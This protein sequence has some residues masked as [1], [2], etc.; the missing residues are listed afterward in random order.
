MVLDG[1]GN[2]H[3][4]TGIV[5]VVVLPGRPQYLG[6]EVV[7]LRRAWMIFRKV[8]GMGGGTEA[9]DRPTPLDVRCNHRQLFRWQLSK[10]KIEH[11]EIR[12]L[13]RL[14]PFD[15]VSGPALKSLIDED[16]RL[17]SVVTFQE[18]RHRRH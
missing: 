9:D 11:R 7:P 14:K 2:R 10:S 17:E 3:I 8:E 12:R 18:I 15:V 16:R 13:Q 6:P 4:G 1:I 5:A